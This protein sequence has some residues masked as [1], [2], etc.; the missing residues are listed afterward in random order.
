[1]EV[2]DRGQIVVDGDMRSVSH[3]DVYAVGDAG[4]AIGDAGKPLRMSCAS[5]IPMAWIAADA[6]AAGLTG[7]QRGK[8]PLGYF[9]QCISLG[10]KNGLIQFVTSDDQ[11]RLA[12]LRGFTAMV[13]KEFICKGAAWSVAN[14]TLGLPVRRKHIA[15]TETIAGTA[16]K[17][18]A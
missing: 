8:V 17:A 1:M 10:R 9:Q 2:T 13:Y 7:G 6:I 3:P 14:P 16:I 4:Y 11:A 12:S 18:L 15:Q 5:G